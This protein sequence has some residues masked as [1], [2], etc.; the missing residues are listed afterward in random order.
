MLSQTLVGYLTQE[1]VCTHP[2]QRI[3]DIAVVRQFQIDIIRIYQRSQ[4]LPDD[5]LQ[6]AAY[7]LLFSLHG[8]NY[9][10]YMVYAKVMKFMDKSFN[11]C[12]Y[13]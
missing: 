13:L 4:P 11:E 7:I 8:Y 3:T 1:M 6:Y 10:L 2:Y 12:E 5:L 9:Y